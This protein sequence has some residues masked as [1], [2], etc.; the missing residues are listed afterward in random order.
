MA[1]TVYFATT[2]LPPVGIAVQLYVSWHSSTAVP[3]RR[4]KGYRQFSQS[5]GDNSGAVTLCWFKPK[6]SQLLSL[7]EYNVSCYSTEWK[8]TSSHVT[9]ASQ[10]NQI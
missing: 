8:I 10:L 7:L 1:A 3:W 5:N 6:R 9:Q 4:S 2:H